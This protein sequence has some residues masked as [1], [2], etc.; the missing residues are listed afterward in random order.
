[1]AEPVL[2]FARGVLER[3]G[4][5][6]ELVLQLLR[7]A[8]LE[9]GERPLVDLAEPLAPGL[10]RLRLAYILKQLPDHRRDADQLGGLLDDGA[11][12]VAG[13]DHWQGL[14]LFRG[15]I[16]LVLARHGSNPTNPP[17]RPRPPTRP[18]H[19]VKASRRP[20]SAPRPVG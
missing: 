14:R 3:Q 11:L 17:P 6:L 5:R 18:G 7:H 20:P 15:R 10:V 12:R 16:V 13:E 19:A 1:M 8:F 2:G 4:Q 9:R